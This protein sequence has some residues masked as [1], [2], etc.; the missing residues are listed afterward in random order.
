MPGT[1]HLEGPRVPQFVIM[2]GPPAAGKTSSAPALADALGFPLFAMDRIKERLAD[3]IGPHASSLAAQLGDA[4]TL[5][6]VALATDVLA[7]GQ[8]VM[9][10]GFFRAEHLEPMLAPLVAK[11]QAV[12]VHVWAD[13]ALL[14][15]RFRQRALR[16]ERHWIHGDVALI[17]SLQPVLPDDMR[18]PLD[19]GIARVF[20]DT[21][22]GPMDFP[23]V[24]TH[25]GMQS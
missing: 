3:A 17:A 11:A 4:A 10:E 9:I 12:L 18:R 25:F 7:A 6:L 1:S 23:A 19:L 22:H 2:S 14:M 13:D 8:D 15:E 21:S 16:H 24:D 20:V 5:Q